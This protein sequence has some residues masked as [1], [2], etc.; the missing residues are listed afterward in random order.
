MTKAIRLICL[1]LFASVSAAFAQKWEIGV[2]SG[3][4]GYVGDLNPYKVYPTA[5]MKYS[6]GI[7]GS[8]KIKPHVGIRLNANYINLAGSDA[9]S[10]VQENLGRGLSFT[11]NI[12]ESSLVADLE[13]F[14]FYS[15]RTRFRYTPYIFGGVGAMFNDAKS[16]DGLSYIGNY[17]EVLNFDEIDM[18]TPDSAFVPKQFSRYNFILPVGVG[19]KVNL[20]GPFSVGI[21]LNYRFPIG[22]G[23]DMLDGVSGKYIPFSAINGSSLTQNDWEKLSAGNFAQ[24]GPYSNLVNT[25]RGGQV[26]YDSYLTTV[27][28]IGYSLYQFRDATWR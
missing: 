23:N 10:G 22:N 21:Q 20:A 18:I 17:A 4:S 13:F 26:K 16:V 11:N 28:T 19:F 15:D 14:T 27:F 3:V 25:P 1:F 5:N 24:P 8:Y 2:N 9:T 12:F 6:G 7:F